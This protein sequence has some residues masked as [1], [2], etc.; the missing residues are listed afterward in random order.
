MVAGNWGS[1]LKSTFLPHIQFSRD[2]LLLIVG[3][4]GTTISPYLFFWQ[5]AQE[6]EEKSE[7]FALTHKMPRVTKRYVASMRID[8]FFGMLFSEIA[9][10]FIIVTAAVVL[11]GNGI[12]DVQ[13]ASQAAQAIEPLVHGFPH[14]GI[15]AK[16]LFSIGIIGGGLLAVPI[17]AASSSYA[18]SE[19]FNWDEGL[20]KRFNE[21]KGFYGV[22]I[23]GGAVGLLMNFLHINP[24]K[25]LVYTAVI[26]G[27]VSIPIIFMI[28]RICGNKKVMGKHVNGLWSNISGWLAFLAV[29][30]AGLLSL[31][32]FIK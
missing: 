23:A 13:S 32:S 5:T 14:A 1:L 18:V 31:Y 19:I 11:H 16:L 22:L 10:W 3:V 26:N 20:E 4:I 2:F 21:A 27:F 30:C 12:T 29:L 25:A 15:L 24:I 8:T 17:F 6:V 28:L 9:T 7:R